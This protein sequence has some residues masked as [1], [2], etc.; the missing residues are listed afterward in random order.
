MPFQQ[1]FDLA[2]VLCLFADLNMVKID[3]WVCCNS[4]SSSN[5]KL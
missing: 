5:S 2:H 1:I 3:L 4:N